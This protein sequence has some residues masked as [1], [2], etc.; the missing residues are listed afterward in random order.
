L[1]PHGKLALLLPAARESEAIS[2]AATHQ[3]WP[4][5]IVTVK[6]T[7]AHAGFRVMLLLRREKI[8]VTE[9]TLIIRE[10]TG[11]SNLFQ[12]LMDDYYL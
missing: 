2:L 10:G 6:Q 5:E 4:E 8:Q 3:F 7:P 1:T 11:Y 9:T 12:D